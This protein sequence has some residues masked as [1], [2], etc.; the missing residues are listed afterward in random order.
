[1]NFFMRLFKKKRVIVFGKTI[2][3]NCLHC[4]NNYSKEDVRCTWGENDVQKCGHYVYDPIKRKPKKT[5]KLLAY[6][7][8]DFEI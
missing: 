2:E 8:K 4:A 7:E 3:A 6:T 5:A 1:M